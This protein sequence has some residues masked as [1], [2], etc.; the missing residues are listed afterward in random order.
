MPYTPTNHVPKPRLIQELDALGMDPR[1]PRSELVNK[2]MQ[3][4]IY[5]INTDYPPPVKF[6]DTSCKFPNHSSVLIGNGATI[7]HQQDEK[8]IICNKPKNLPLIE[9]DFST[10]KISFNKC[11]N[12]QESEHLTCDTPGVDGDIRRCEDSLYMY[13]SINVHPGWYPLNFG[14]MLLI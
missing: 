1:G 14:T 9:G 10:N 11:I 7:H 2:L 6:N 4:G 3:S 12:I 13:R 5:Q 8:L